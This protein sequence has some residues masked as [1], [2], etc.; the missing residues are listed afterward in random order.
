MQELFQIP[1]VNRYTL[2]HLYHLY[3]LEDLPR[4]TDRTSNRSPVGWNNE[5]QVV[6]FRAK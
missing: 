2:Y 6:P 1:G 4:K 5:L 3:H